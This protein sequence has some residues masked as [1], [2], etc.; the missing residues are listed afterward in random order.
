MEEEIIIFLLGRAL[1]LTLVV[2]LPVIIPAML[3]G[4]AVSIFQAVTQIQDN[5]LSFVPKLIVM[6]I[7]IG[8]CGKWIF[9]KILI[10]TQE[11]FVLISHG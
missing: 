3:I 2:T 4:L 9:E 1:M 10:F 5:S 6:F 11:I 7:V 8:L